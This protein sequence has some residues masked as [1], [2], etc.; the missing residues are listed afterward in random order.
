MN[1]FQINF[2]LEKFDCFIGVYPRNL[3]PRKPIKIRPCA[4]IINTDK[5]TEPGEHWVALYL[6]KNTYA[7]YF[8]SFG[9]SPNHIEII[10]FLQRNKIKKIV[11]NTNQLQSLT[12]LTCGAYCVLFVKFRFSNL[13]FCDLINFFSTNSENND[14]ASLSLLL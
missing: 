14:I 7:E 3:L 4:L 6:S 10:K 12:S 13:N 9:F 11:Y 2:L 1:T 5:S 8:D